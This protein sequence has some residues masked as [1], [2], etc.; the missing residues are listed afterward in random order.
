ML[1]NGAKVFRPGSWTGLWEMGARLR[2][3]AL[4]RL[5]IVARGV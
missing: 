2:R 3:L 5:G 4:R 1:R